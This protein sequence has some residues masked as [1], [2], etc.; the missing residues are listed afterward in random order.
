MKKHVCEFPTLWIQTTLNLFP[1]KAVGGKL[2]GLNYYVSKKVLHSSQKGCNTKFA[3]RNHIRHYLIYGRIQVSKG[4]E[5]FF[6]VKL[7]LW[8]S[9]CWH[10]CSLKMRKCHLHIWLWME[11][12]YISKYEDPYTLYQIL[13]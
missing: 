1:G 3:T 2:W 6:V 13:C 5:N 11:C 7:F 10:I 12:K 4:V 9:K 8:G